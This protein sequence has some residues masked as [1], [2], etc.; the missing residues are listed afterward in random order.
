MLSR[1]RSASLVAAQVNLLETRALLSAAPATVPL[2]SQVGKQ[3]VADFLGTW[4]W[5]YE[6]GGDGTFTITQNGN[7]LN[8]SFSR[9]TLLMGEGP[10]KVKGDRMK[11]KFE[12]TT[13]VAFT[14][15]M[16]TTLTAPGEVSGTIQVKYK[17]AARP[18]SFKTGISAVRL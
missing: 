5:E 1:R 15:V 3:D 18:D 17:G 7:K 16:K 10:V 2:A 12:G 13:P 8:G 14:A 9:P 11:F 4:A 6:F